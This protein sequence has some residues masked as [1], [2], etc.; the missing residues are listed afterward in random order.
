MI[1]YRSD[2]GV[3]MERRI[4]YKGKIG[5][6]KIG[7][8]RIAREKRQGR[9]DAERKQGKKRREKGEKRTEYARK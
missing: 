1:V 3:M 8:E 2:E 9:M 5:W 4:G 6:S 7:D